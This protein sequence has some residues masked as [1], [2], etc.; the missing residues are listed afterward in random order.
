[1]ALAVPAGL[2]CGP[3]VPAAAPAAWPEVA[4]WLA[5]PAAPP[6]P[7]HASPAAVAAY[8]AG[9]PAAVGAELAR[10]Y[11]RIVGALDGAPVA[12]RLTANAGRYPESGV[13]LYDPRGDGRIAV[14]AG[15]LTVAERV[16]IVV[17]GVD[18]TLA[19]FASGLGGVTRRAPQWQAGQLAAAVA[20]DY[21]D[22]RVAVV[23]WLGYDP[24]DGIRRAALR[25][26]SAAAGAVALQHFV[27]GL[28]ASRP[29][30]RITIVGHSYG[31]V[32]AALA[33]PRLDPAVT[34]IVAIGSPGMAGAHHVGDLHTAARVW[35]GSAPDD[36][37]RKLPGVRV[38]GVGHG[39]LPISADFGALPLPAGDVAGHDGYFV[40][41]TSSLRALAAIAAGHPDAVAGP[42]APVDPR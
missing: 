28:V 24:P 34:D 40:P 1:M 13:L 9:T 29:G 33:A 14:V 39:R 25:E 20:R 4:Q 37:T 36:W 35:A 41:G 19:N 17:P 10:R 42:S 38:L 15:D 5:D 2:V 23:A 18:T 3:T 11:P 8:F 7:V 22:A 30:L 27:A 12:L 32:V 31:S 6:D 26:D 16:A 21:P